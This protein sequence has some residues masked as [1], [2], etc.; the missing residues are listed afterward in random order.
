MKYIF[1]FIICIHA[2]I[3]L[4]GF[5]KAY[6]LARVSQLTQHISRQ[7][8]VAWLVAALLFIAAATL[9]LLDQ[10]YWWMIGVPAI[11]ISQTMIF[12][13]WSDAKFGT[14]ATV[15][16]L[17]PLVMSIANALPGSFRS[18]YRM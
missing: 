9:Y 3:H 1:F 8:G 16:I 13:S 2:L 15:I 14:I 12:L 6:N 11:L 5:V 18:M 10:E 17:A 4:L 7:A